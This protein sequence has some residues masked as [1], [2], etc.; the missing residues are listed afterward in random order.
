M[1]RRVYT[2]TNTDW[3]ILNIISTIGAVIIALSVLVFIVQHPQ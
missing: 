1:P 2:Y 3:D